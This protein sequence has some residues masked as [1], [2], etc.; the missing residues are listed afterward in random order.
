MEHAHCP[1]CADSLTCC[2]GLCCLEA[3]AEFWLVPG[4]EPEEKWFFKGKIILLGVTLF[5][6]Q[7]DCMLAASGQGQSN[8]ENRFQSDGWC[9]WRKGNSRTKMGTM[10]PF[11]DCNTK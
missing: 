8:Q 1:L 2:H 10:F 4:K 5:C 9:R 7:I 6:F 11:T 3:A